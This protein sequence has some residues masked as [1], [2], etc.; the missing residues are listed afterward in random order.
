MGANLEKID[1]EQDMMNF[2]YGVWYDKDNGVYYVIDEHR[3]REYDDT[4]GMKT[5][6][7]KDNVDYTVKS[8][9]DF[10][11]NALSSKSLTYNYCPFTAFMLCLCY[12]RD[13][14]TIEMNL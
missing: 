3:C 8:F 1:S 13:K 2:F 6:M 12:N 4:I 5:Y 7:Q 11:S 14:K 9:E 10:Y